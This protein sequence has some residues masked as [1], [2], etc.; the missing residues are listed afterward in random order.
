ML[1]RAVS[2]LLGRPA[3][4]LSALSAGPLR[5]ELL[6]AEAL[7]E[8]ARASARAHRLAALGHGARDTPL[9]A[10]LAET[11]SILHTARARLAAEADARADVGPAGEWLLDNFHVVREHLR[12]VRESL[13]AGYYRELP[14]LAGGRLAGYPRVYDLATTLISH[15]E[16]RVDVHNA[17][18][19]VAAFQ[20]EA[21]LTLGEL[22]AVP[23]M[24]RLGLLES[25]RRMALRTVQRLD[26]T[27]AA[28]AWAAR[29]DTAAAAGERALASEL[30]AFAETHPP[31]SPLF[32]SRLLHQVRLGHGG[33]PALQGWLAAVGV[34]AERAV[35]QAAQ[36]LALTQMMMANSITSL[37]GIGLVDWGAFVERHSAVEE[38]LR[39]DPAGFYAAMTF[40]TRDRYRHAVERIAKGGGRGE[41]EVARAAV[42]LAASAGADDPRWSHVGW[43]LV[44]GGQAELERAQGYRP[45]ARERA[46]RWMLGHP[47]V[48]FVGGIVL[49]TAPVLAAVLRVTGPGLRAAPAGAGAL[50]AL[51]AAALA[52]EVAV[53]VVNQLVAA[54][55]PLRLLPRL[56]LYEQGGIPAGMR[57]AVVVPI[58]F[59]GVEAVHEALAHLEVQYLANRQPNLHFAL[60][61]DFTDAAAE[62]LPGD[63]EIASAAVD[64]VRA[65][66][67]R[68][69]AGAGDAFYLFLRP[70]R[71]NPCEGA[72]MGWERK[73]GKLA[74][75][76]RFVRGGS[77][78]A[79]SSVVGDVAALRGV[80]YV[81]TLDADTVL[82]PGTAA[83]LVGALAHPLN[84]A[85]YDPR[86]GRVTRG[87][88][89]LQ[90]RVGVSL[91]S[92]HAS[93][94]AAIHSG[95][96]G[97]DPYTT[98]VSDVYQDL[99]GEGSFTGKG[100]YDLDAFER[101]THGRFPENALLSHDLI[102]GSYARAGLATDLEVY[103]DYPARYLTHARRR[104][105]WIRGDWQLLRWLGPRV[106]GPG[107]R[108]PNRLSLVS[109]WKILDNLRRSTV[110]IAQLAFFAAGWLLLPGSPLRW[111]VLGVLALAAPWIV[112][113]LLA[114][115]RPPRDRSWR[116]WYAAVG[117]DAATGARQV[118]LAL[119]FLPHHA[120]LSA[121][122]IARTLWR[123]F[124]T[125]RHLLQWQTA[126][127]AER[128]VSSSPRAAWR[129]MGPAVALA[130]GIGAVSLAARRGE[131]PP[132]PL[133]AAVLP[134]ALLWILSP[135]IAHALGK[136]SARGGGR[137]SPAAR[138]QALR[139]ALL[140]WR[141][142]DRFVTA[143][144]H[145]LVPDNFQ[146]DPQPVV[147]MRTSPTNLGLQLLATASACDLGFITVGEMAGRLETAFRA[148]ERMRR[149]RG[150]F[151]NWYDLNDLSVLEPAYVST[152]DSGN[153]AGHLVALR[154]ACLEIAGRA[155]DHGRTARAL[156][157]AFSLAARRLH[158]LATS[159][160]VLGDASARAAVAR[161]AEQLRIARAQV[162]ARAPSAGTRDA[163]HAALEGLRA[164]GL[165]PDGS[166][167]AAEWIAWSLRRIE[168]ER[169]CG[170]ELG[171]VAAGK[172]GGA[173]GRG[174][175]GDAGPPTLRARAAR[176]TAASELVARLQ[177]VAE[178]AYRY[179][180][181]MDF[182]FLFDG[183]RKLFSIGYQVAAHA[184]DRS[185]YD[186]LAS[187]A[188]LAS[189]VAI[190]R[191]DVPVEHWFRL[192]RTLTHAAGHTALVSWTG[193]MFEYL[194]PALVM[195]SLPDT[196]LGQSCSGAVRR[197]IAY[198]TAHG[199]PWGISE[200][201]YNLRERSLT[202][203]Y[204]AF[205]VPDLALKRGLGRD[206][207]VA[208]Y[209]SAL[210]ALVEPRRALANLTVLEKMGA[211]G[212]YGF[213]DAVDYT[214]PEL[215][216]RFA[217]V[218][219]Y[220]AHHA[221][222]TLVA[223]DN[224]LDDAPW[225]RRFHA[226]PLVRSAELL[227]HERIP[228]SLALQEPQ[229]AHPSEA[230]P[231]PATETESLG[232][233]EFYRP[234]TRRPHVA[235][236][237]W[238]PY[239]L[240]VNQGGSGYSQYRDLA[241]TGWRADGTNN[242]TGQ[243]CYVRDIT[244][245]RTWSAPHQ[246]V[247][248]P[249]DAYRAVLA[250]DRVTFHRTDGKVETRTEITVVPEDHAEVRR[251]TVTNTGD[252]A[253]EV[254][255]TSYGEVVLGSPDSKDNQELAKH[256]V[257]I[258]WDARLTAII[259]TRLPHS[260]LQP[261]PW[262]VHVVDDGTDRVGPVS[263]ETD[264]A[265]F[266]GREGTMRAPAAL[267][268]D[269]L[270]GVDGAVLDPIFSLRIRV[271]VQPSKPVSVAFTT[272]VATTREHALKLA[273]RYHDPYAAQRAF[274]LA[275][276]SQQVELQELNLT[277]ADAAIFQE[278][279]SEILYPRPEL[280]VAQNELF[281]TMAAKRALSAHGI[282]GEYP[283]ILA[284]IDSAEGLPSLRQ[285]LA[286]HDYLRRRGILVDLILVNTQPLFNRELHER[287]LE[288]MFA[289]GDTEMDC[290]G[291]VFVRRLDVLGT[292]ALVTIQTIAHLS[293][294]CDGRSLVYILELGPG[295]E[296][297]A[298]GSGVGRS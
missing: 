182:R 269:E 195:R 241:I 270:S 237:G 115:A 143:E 212:P 153:L 290:P 91:P 92:A 246:P 196:L 120:W 7:A 40:A 66:N 132:L 20:E 34:S 142:F 18:L 298:R 24:L 205:G 84:R 249:A 260:D 176:S 209:A 161:A 236:L 221:G 52:C 197:Q 86:A 252:R 198:G 8:R 276:T 28:D 272:L 170:R 297:D 147:A 190:A 123:L 133:L 117:R 42:A 263:Y 183:E 189:F 287:I 230:L 23:A 139:Y 204:R 224:V 60:L 21:P 277:P 259:A 144:T 51:L 128:T 134:L 9:L 180:M 151:H 79:F 288:A 62:T 158:E 85:G 166:A 16:G 216:E 220:M 266:L 1:L 213:R 200:S 283:I 251:V 45:T 32:A 65:L 165:A 90:P 255:L 109:R 296:E 203:R 202:Y 39:G 219:N 227:L 240:M 58:L 284:T 29:I 49:G 11:R 111:T 250:T 138:A 27:E 192:R 222:M 114:A 225:Q 174:D 63:A 22:W 136:P 47:D 113:L 43:W 162:D 110:E 217:V 95:H 160:A 137:L 199:V 273:S 101:A 185:T 35:A 80:R 46:H 223:L 14:E 116:A 118:G 258:E 69:A 41:A 89:I 82:P 172:A 206:L 37:R 30:R 157:V 278:M 154:Q 108:E 186:L 245:E 131:T 97:V 56:D 135:A 70:R 48:A 194:M 233:R 98:A 127:V 173:E 171:A 215:G 150:H 106:P 3:P 125:R 271:R 124:V 71:W 238:A 38:V 104:H 179:A 208:P 281:Q 291:G 129:A 229:G 244:G 267:T 122:A 5:G 19:F 68:Y 126:S 178:R 93:R 248:A 81:I 78:G 87:Y 44:D 239:T 294:P 119:A 74:E 211:L 235:L 268:V 2:R 232:V 148:L 247:C 96:P 55:L 99:Y 191:G 253:R 207:V 261:T 145:G 61:G 75:F 121:D 15:T 141:Y 265:R 257:K 105:R 83:R 156:E 146:E 57:T 234:D 102:E 210:A 177:A 167:P 130:A 149:F 72:W 243:F 226:N 25:V 201:A 289:A 17:G 10:R 53:G 214:R 67:T 231:D 274:D 285:L 193:S 140:H 112:S 54:F 275:R 107:G 31:L 73:R 77:A 169:A 282:S 218:N 175:G 295:D 36:R 163:L 262:C 50:M 256:F 188:R 168:E 100:I 292:N 26:E 184:L 59:D 103:D 13:P 94:F 242:S 64:G 76:N 164:A 254:E 155:V 159:P 4:E 181:E 264:R 12:E 279:A 280:L 286:G 33:L 293:V 187:E 152:V 88:G 6:G 228:R